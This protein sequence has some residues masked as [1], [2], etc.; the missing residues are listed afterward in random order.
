MKI[1]LG[2]LAPVTDGLSTY[3]QKPLVISRWGYTGRVLN[4][5][6]LAEDS[7]RWQSSKESSR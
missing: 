7:G 2:L 3:V 4:E 5:E 1:K 6:T